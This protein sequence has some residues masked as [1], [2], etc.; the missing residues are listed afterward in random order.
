MGE[1]RGNHENYYH[2][3]EVL[4]PD[5]GDDI[6][7][8]IDDDVVNNE[9][10][11]YD[12]DIYMD[13]DIVDN[14]DP[15]FNDFDVAM[16][17]DVENDELVFDK[18][19]GIFSLNVEA[20]GWNELLIRAEGAGNVQIVE[21]FVIILAS[22]LYQKGSYKMMLD[23]FRLSNYELNKH[24]FPSDMKAFWRILNRRETDFSYITTC[25]I[26]NRLLGGRKRPQVDCQCGK[27]GPNRKNSELG[28]YLFINLRS[29]I[30][31]L[32]SK[33]GMA[34]DLEYPYT[35]RKRN[36]DAIE[37]VYDGSEYKRLS[38][39][40][41]FLW[42]ENHNYSLALWTDGASP[43]DSNTVS[44]WPVFV[45]V[46]ELSPLARQRHTMLA[47]VY[48]GPRK[49]LIHQ[50]LTPVALELRDLYTNG[51]TWSPNANQERRSYFLTLIV[52][53]D[54]EGR[55][56]IFGMMRHS[57]GYGCTFCTANGEK[58]GRQLSYHRNDGNAADRTYAEIRRDALES[59]ETDLPQRGVK[60]HS[61]LSI[62]PE[63]DL[64]AGQL[65]EPMHCLWEGNFVRLFNN[66]T[67]TN[68]ENHLL[69]A[70]IETISNR[71][72]AIRTPTKLFSNF[73]VTEYRNTAWYYWL[74]CAQ[75]FLL[76][77]QLR[78]CAA[79]AEATFILNKDS[80]L[81]DELNRAEELLDEY[82]TN[83]ENYFLHNQ[84]VYNVHL[85]KHI[86][87][88]VRELGPLFVA[89]GF[90][91]E[92][93]NRHIVNFITS[94]NHRAEQIA[95][96]MLMKKMLEK[97]IEWPL[98]LETEDRLRQLMG[99]EQWDVPPNIATGRYIRYKGPGIRRLANAQE[100]AALRESDG[101]ANVN[102]RIVINVHKKVCI[103]GVKYQPHSDKV[104]KYNNSIAYVSTQYRG[105]QV[106]FVNITSIVTWQHEGDEREGL[107]GTLFNVIGPAF[108]T[109]YM[110]VVE[111]SQDLVYVPLTSVVTP[112]VLV[113]SCGNM[114]ISR[115]PNRWDND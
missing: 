3:E 82:R 66:F 109:T 74:P 31:S 91:F 75:D 46:L 6:Y 73:T 41:Q 35:R 63:F 54:S 2:E 77:D 5:Y 44:I 20:E 68:R 88:C 36:V 65:V 43:V 9:D 96:R 85:L 94:P 69:P 21:K 115:L 26:C 114:Y 92:S 18:P 8:Y 49:P 24:I 81:L 50:L 51:V 1:R 99:K 15:D 104:T 101:L 22:T 111:P 64:R 48:V 61:P 39:E 42:R 59:T 72:T 27:C 14:E 112:A 78:L 71:I 102:E 34:R 12:D 57:G 28:T 53:A 97:F 79:F 11:D 95:C 89:S 55:Y 7:I 103:D 33:H 107:F 29:Q 38:Q 110:M 47:A 86:V 108:G 106:D 16:E 90:W 25:T 58:R 56:I 13:D 19:R 84:L 70:A 80:I 45:Q 93:L 98:S 52:S 60:Y 17:D 23:N 10:P 100:I 37:D 4:A 105:Q 30:A 113:Q 83:Y 62:V 40:G 87:R 76:P 32:F 67:I